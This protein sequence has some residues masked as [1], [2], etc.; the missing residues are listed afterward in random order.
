[1]EEVKNKLLQEL[2]RITQSFCVDRLGVFLDQL[3]LK[4]APQQTNQTAAEV[5]TLVQ[6]PETAHEEFIEAFQASIAY[7]FVDFQ[8]LLDYDADLLEFAE[9]THEAVTGDLAMPA[10]LDKAEQCFAEL[11]AR[12]NQ[13]L[14]AV[15]QCEIGTATNPLAP[16]HFALALES[17]V[18][19]LTWN[20]HTRV[21][22][23]KVFDVEF[24]SHL[25]LL[26]S[27]IDQY[28][29]GQ[30]ILPKLEEGDSN[31]E[32]GVAPMEPLP[33][34]M[35]RSAAPPAV[36]Q[37]P[38]DPSNTHRVGAAEPVAANDAADTEIIQPVDHVNQLFSAFLDKRS[39]SEQLV[40]IFSELYLPYVQLASADAAFVNADDHPAKH[41]LHGLTKACKIYEEKADDLQKSALLL[42]MK[43]VVRR[44]VQESESKRETFA[45]AAFRFS[46]ALRQHERQIT[47]QPKTPQLQQSGLRHLDGWKQHVS[48][49]I[50][51]KLA[52]HP[53][54]VPEA[55]RL[56][57][58]G[59]WLNY[60]AGQYLNAATHNVQPTQTLA[61]VD[62]ILA[63]VAPASAK[64]VP[65]FTAIA[66]P[67]RQSLVACD[68]E[69]KE[70]K[71][72]LLQ[73]MHF[74]RLAL[75]TLQND[76]ALAD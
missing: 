30:S 68:V 73:M 71:Q 12:L 53:E 28:L 69:D 34:D 37:D 2:Q 23:L 19:D 33:A 56:F 25:G 64:N 59:P 43:S 42:E 54:A 26:Y 18:Q 74:H 38:A 51:S 31:D 10:M 6:L 63:Y 29:T 45:D 8:D 47:K 9:T 62:E 67:V 50:S 40:N 13:R 1:M 61:L 55:V 16:V 21:V 20:L 70:I 46:A 5:L 24:L 72:F 17:A 49:V 39:L 52:A 60:M 3:A 65:E 7:T 32:H 27:E 15:S 11:L 48:H 41:L 4:S 75:R 57:L 14:S 66:P 76:V 22:A 58:A 36:P 35:E 44:V